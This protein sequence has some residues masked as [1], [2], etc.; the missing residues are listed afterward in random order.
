M[1]KEAGEEMETEKRE[2]AFSVFHGVRSDLQKKVEEALALAQGIKLDLL[3]D[4]PPSPSTPD[5]QIK[6]PESFSGIVGEGIGQT[7]RTMNM[8]ESIIY[9]LQKIRAEI[10]SYEKNSNSQ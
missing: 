7:K 4:D 3:G 8:V 9:F 2:R 6:A 1:T 5:K 10:P